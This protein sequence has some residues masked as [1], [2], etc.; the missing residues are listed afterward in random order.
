MTTTD[1]LRCPICGIGV[2]QDLGFD[3]GATS[4]DDRPVQDPEARQWTR[5]S[6][7][8]QVEGPRLETADEARLDV[9]RRTSEDTTDVPREGT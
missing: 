8:H 5:F 7:G 4:P 2:V 6:C 3:A 9:E 1:E